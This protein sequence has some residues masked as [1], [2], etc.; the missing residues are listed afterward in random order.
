MRTH[1]TKAA[2]KLIHNSR[3]RSD[4]AEFYFNQAGDEL[5]VTENERTEFELEARVSLDADVLPDALFAKLRV[6]AASR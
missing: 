3:D 4:D 2:Q 5:A 1:H 6:F